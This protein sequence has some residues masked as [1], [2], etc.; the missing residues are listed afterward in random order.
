MKEE[1][2]YALDIL[3][4]F[5]AGMTFSELSGSFGV[6]VWLGDLPTRVL[7]VIYAIIYHC[8]GTRDHKTLYHLVHSS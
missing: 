6:G 1:L 7:R 2:P 4:R 3:A 5:L 8:H